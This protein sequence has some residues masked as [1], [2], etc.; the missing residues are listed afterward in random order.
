MPER[1]LALSQEVSSI[2]TNRVDEI[3][4]I[5]RI[6]KILGINAAIEAGRS[7]NPGFGIVANEV[8]TVSA[9]IEQLTEKLH[10]ELDSKTNELK[11]LGQTLIAQIR[12]SRLADLALN[13]ID[14][15]DRNLY[16][17]SCDVR[18]WATD[19]AVVECAADP[20]PNRCAWAAKRLGVILDSY[21]VYLDL[22]IAGADGKVLANGRPQKYPVRD[23]DVSG[24]EWFRK[25]LQT[26][27]GADFVACDITP[28]PSLGGVPVA[29]YSTAIRH[30]GEGNGKPAGVLGIFFDWGQQSQAVVNSVRLTPEERATTTC[31]LLS[32]A[33]TV[34]ASTRPDT[35]EPHTFPLKTQGQKIGSYV[36]SAGNLI[37]FALT[38]GYE[39]YA[40]LG[41]YGAIVQHR[42]Q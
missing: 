39:T 1:V 15:I 2:A 5:T 40:G 19:S 37:G 13:M 17:R 35:H 9:A 41:W 36:D 21:T 26:A 24:E 30:G 16:E 10:S 23:L 27:S 33:H 28:S 34:I 32:A 38:P 6:T 7:H 42:E 25:G 29:A 8:G 3:R 12:G 31:M 11:T 20:A 4:R 22:W 14:I 18:W